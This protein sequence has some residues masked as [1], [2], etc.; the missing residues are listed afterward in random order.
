MD[1]SRMKTGTLANECSR[2]E[3]SHTENDKV[4]VKNKKGGKNEEK[5]NNA[6]IDMVPAVLKT[7]T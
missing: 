2:K 5:F 7:E 4:H 1:T 3:T 6:N